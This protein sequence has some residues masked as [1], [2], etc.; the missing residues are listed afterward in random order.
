GVETY[1]IVY[2]TKNTD[3]KE[4][5]ASGALVLPIGLQGTTALA[6]YQ[7]GT[8]LPEREFLAPSYFN[9]ASEATVGSF[10]ASTGYIMAMPDYIG[11]GESKNLP[12]PYEHRASLAESSVDFLFA[13]K[14]FLTKEKSPWNQ[15]LL[16][17]GFSEG[18]Y[19]TLSL[20]KLIEEKYANDFKLKASA[21]GAGA[22]NKTKTVEQ[23]F[24]TKSSGETTNNK[25]Y[26]WVLQT[27][28]RLY[29]I[30]KPLA[31]H[32]VEP[33]ASD[34]SKNG[35]QVNIN[36]SFNEIIEPTFKDQI[37]KNSDVAW[38]D[39]IKDNDLLDWKTTTPTRF[40]HGLNDTFVP[41]LNSETT[42]ASLKA[43]GST[44]VSFIPITNGTHSNQTTLTQY[45]LGTLDLFSLYKSR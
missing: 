11:Y 20:Q 21:V 42:V 2:K 16:L 28:H 7:H 41:V 15:N 36:R 25:S 24:S 18:G 17:T 23:L 38:K 22:Y 37:L 33:F 1:K 13:V 32:F 26:I 35:F 31:S 9:I 8:I 39:A 27:Y 12:H 34:I 30:S 3:G 29:N 5:N 14:E 19:A 45:Y 10:L 4:I 43:K 6:S 40:Y 44:D